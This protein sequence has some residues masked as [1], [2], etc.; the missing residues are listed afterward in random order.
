MR[1]AASGSPVA[2]K[3]RAAQP[4]NKVK[5]LFLPVFNLDLQ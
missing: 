5:I 3:L 1:L 2:A 4:G